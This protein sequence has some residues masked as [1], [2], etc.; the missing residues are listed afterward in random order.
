[1]HRAPPVL[2]TALP[3][4]A[5]LLAVAAAT[6]GLADEPPA[7][8]PDRPPL[9]VSPPIDVARHQ[10][11]A[12][13]LRKH[14]VAV[15]AQLIDDAM[16][17]VADDPDGAAAARFASLTAALLATANDLADRNDRLE[18]QLASR[19]A[20]TVRPPPPDMPALINPDAGSPPHGLAFYFGFGVFIAILG[21]IAIGT[22]TLCSW[23]RRGFITFANW[24]QEP[25]R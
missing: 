10:P 15:L 25:A 19:P 17:E 4:L 12:A 16:K 6:P 7:P 14:D 11:A 2:R 3:A 18:Q 23:A 9:T 24:L 1:M 5:T 8:P 22:L 21:L 13:R 20:A